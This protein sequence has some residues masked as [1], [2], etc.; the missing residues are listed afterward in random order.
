MIIV[1]QLIKKCPHFLF[2]PKGSLMCLL[3]SATGSCPEPFEFSP[4]PYTLKGIPC[5]HGMCILRLQ[6]RRHSID[7]ESTCEYIESAVMDS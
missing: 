7:V 4:Q 3:E 6:W 1:A 2:E 5:H